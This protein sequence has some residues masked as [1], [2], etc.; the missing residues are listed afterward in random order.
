[1]L[2]EEHLVIYIRPESLIINKPLPEK[3]FQIQ[4]KE[5][6]PI[7]KGD[8]L[9]IVTSP[10]YKPY[11]YQGDNKTEDKIKATF[12]L[13]KNIKTFLFISFC[14]GVVS[15]AVLITKRYFGWGI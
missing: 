9:E 4:I 6:T 11:Y 10:N 1:L 7:Y 13:K 2:C 8:S 3:I 15:L 5:G 12:Y 14:V